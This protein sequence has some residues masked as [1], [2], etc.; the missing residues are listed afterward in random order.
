M[1]GSPTGDVGELQ[2]AMNAGAIGRTMH[3]RV[4]R[5][6]RVIDLDVIPTELT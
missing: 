1:D 2:R 6:D 4:L 5:G 3:L